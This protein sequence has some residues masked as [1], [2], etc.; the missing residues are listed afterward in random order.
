MLYSSVIIYSPA[1]K[2]GRA[3]KTFFGG[4]SFS[5]AFSGV[6]CE[7]WSWLVWLASDVLVFGNH[8]LLFGTL[9]VVANLKYMR[10]FAP[11]RP[12]IIMSWAFGGIAWSETDITTSRTEVHGSIPK[13]APG[14]T[15]L[16]PK[17]L[18]H[19][20][21]SGQLRISWGPSG[22]DVVL[23]RVSQINHQKMGAWILN[24]P[25]RKGYYPNYGLNALSMTMGGLGDRAA[26]LEAQT[27]V[28]VVRRI[29][30]KS[31]FGSPGRIPAFAQGRTF[32]WGN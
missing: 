21:R 16:H 31:I 1:S 19:R 20:L 18:R 26:G 23:R 5:E 27:T 17:G 22:A 8:L 24:Y 13:T 14:S 10:A 29:H 3:N 6:A 9:R 7:S 2:H 32:V 30:L 25:L 11:K 15:G 12:S 4:N 28:S